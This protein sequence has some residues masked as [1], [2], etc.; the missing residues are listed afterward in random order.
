[1]DGGLFSLKK[2]NSIT[3]DIL[4]D[5]SDPILEK[6]EAQLWFILFFLG[7]RG[8]SVISLFDLPAGH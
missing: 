1:M 8:E 2:M 4:F 5:I 3:T 6:N 7:G